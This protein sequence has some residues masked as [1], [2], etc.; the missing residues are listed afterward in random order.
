MACNCRSGS[1]IIARASGFRE[2]I[3][4]KIYRRP[5]PVKIAVLLI[6]IA[7]VAYLVYQIRD[8]DSDL[9]DRQAAVCEQEGE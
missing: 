4:T 1:R 7:I 9:N 5:T 3:G 6:N 2:V 8:K